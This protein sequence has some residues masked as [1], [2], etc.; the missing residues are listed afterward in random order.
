MNRVL[1]VD[2]ESTIREIIAEALQEAGYDVDTAAHGAE[3]LELIHRSPPE[4]I[5]LDLMMPRLD[6]IGFVD[7]MRLNPQFASVP[8]VLVTAAYGAIQM[9]ERI[10][11]RACITKPFELDELVEAVRRIISEPPRPPVDEQPR[12]ETPFVT[13]A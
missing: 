1:V 4:A 5:I 3:A 12:R 13:E 7:L 2:D 6:G 10:G 8:I 11:A 9:A